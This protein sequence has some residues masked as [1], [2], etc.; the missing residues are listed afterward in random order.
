MVN[1][2]TKEMV[3]RLNSLL[4]MELPLV[5]AHPL[6]VSKAQLREIIVKV[7]RLMDD[8]D[9]CRASLLEAKTSLRRKDDAGQKTL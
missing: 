7:Y 5:P 9:E 4:N 2:K 8:I 6:V 1:L 3:N